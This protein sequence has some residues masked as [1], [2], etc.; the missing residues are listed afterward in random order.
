LTVL[1]KTQEEGNA[2]NAGKGGLIYSLFIF[3]ISQILFKH[4]A[5]KYKVLYGR[6]QYKP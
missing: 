4:L 5:N 1:G 2:G 6:Q 3:N